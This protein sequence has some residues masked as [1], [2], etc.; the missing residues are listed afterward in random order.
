MAC[1]GWKHQLPS[2]R[3]EL[4]EAVRWETSEMSETFFFRPNISRILATV[5]YRWMTD[6]SWPL[7]ADVVRCHRGA[8]CVS[9]AWCYNV[10]QLLYR[11][12]FSGLSAGGSRCW[13]NYGLKWVRTWV[14]PQEQAGFVLCTWLWNAMG[15]WF[16]HVLTCFN[17][18]WL[19]QT[20]C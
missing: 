2:L 6:I 4:G 7:L 5:E 3:T 1:H 19:T 17:K 10:L 18:P 13:H 8:R 16:L 12:A 20:V 11:R 9:V 14:E 15:L